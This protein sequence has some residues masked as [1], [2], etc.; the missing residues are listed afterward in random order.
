VIEKLNRRE[1][2]RER[3]EVTHDLQTLTVTITRARAPGDSVED[4]LVFCR[5]SCRFAR[6]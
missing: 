5:E 3:R 2:L 6:R 4:V 1:I